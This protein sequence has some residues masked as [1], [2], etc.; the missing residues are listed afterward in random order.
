M[1]NNIQEVAQGVVGITGKIVNFYMIGEPH[2]AWVLV[3]ASMP[4]GESAIRQQAANEYGLE[5]KS[6]AIV[7][8]H[9]HFDHIGS[10]NDVK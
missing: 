8:T 5:N 7:L 10:A 9:A 1:A 4:D 2:G 3:D 6:K